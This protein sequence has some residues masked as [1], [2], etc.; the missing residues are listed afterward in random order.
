MVLHIISD[1]PCC[2][3]KTLDMSWLCFMITGRFVVLSNEEMLGTPS[4]PQ[5]ECLKFYW[6]GEENT[7]QGCD[8]SGSMTSWFV[9]NQDGAKHTLIWGATLAGPKEK[10]GGVAV[11]SDRVNFQPIWWEAL[12]SGVKLL[13]ARRAKQGVTGICGRR[14]FNL[15]KK[16]QSKQIKAST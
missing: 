2:L 15:N 1:E 8:N 6:V 10:Q 14:D 16:L 5:D 11:I 13:P 4:H 12:L 9:I 7:P 3:N